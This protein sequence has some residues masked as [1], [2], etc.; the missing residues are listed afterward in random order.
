LP[1]FERSIAL[2]E[3]KLITGVYSLEPRVQEENI[4]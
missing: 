3:G 2:C 4:S 1:C